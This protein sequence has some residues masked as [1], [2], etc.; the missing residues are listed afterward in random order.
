[1]SERRAL[2]HEREELLRQKD[3]LLREK[4]VLLEELQHRVANSLQIVAAIILMKSRSVELRRDAAASAR[5]PQPGHVRRC[6]AA[7]SSH[8]GTVGPIEMAPYLSKLCESLSMSM[9]SNSRPIAL[10]VCS[11][12]GSVTSRE[13]VSLGLIVTELVLNAVKHAFPRDNIDHRVRVPYER[14]R[15]QIGSFR[16]RITASGGGQ[17]LCASKGRPRYQHRE[18]AGAA[19]SMPR[20]RL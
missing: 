18:R 14:R 4:D 1:M 13:A 10:S 2:E 7:A 8:S 6:R 3:A 11:D 20:L 9:I 16:S 17:P 5:C 15:A 12:G 19:S